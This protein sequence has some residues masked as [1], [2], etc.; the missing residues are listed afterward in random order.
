MNAGVL[1][2]GAL[3][4]L[5]A[6]SWGAFKD[7]PFEGFRAGKFARSVALGLA[8]AFLVGRLT[9][10]G[11]VLLLVGLAYCTERLAT[12]WWKAIL[13]EES[14]DAYTIP[15][16]LAFRG[17]TVERRLIRY[18]VG[19][20]VIG[21]LVLTVTGAVALQA[22]GPVPS[23]WTL[24]MLGGL[25]GWLTAVGGAWKD[26]P[27]E[28]FETLKFFRSPVVATLWAWVLLPFTS[29]LP[30]LAIAAAGW[31]VITIETYKTFLAG[32]PPGKFGDKPVRF[33][34]G[35]VR[36]ACRAVHSGLY[37][38]LTGVLAF[39]VFSASLPG[40][41]P[42]PDQVRAELQALVL[43]CGY[44]FVVLIGRAPLPSVPG[45]VVS[46]AVSPARSGESR[47]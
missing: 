2:I 18:T 21:G 22:R 7:S 32:G 45:P 38:A 12:E 20:L 23:S 16:R 37:A 34:S 24:V 35:G 8:A 4:G 40:A 41:E 42:H 26:A 28:G 47:V 15:M 11:D 13:R 3:T 30:V 44:A 9:G 5:H 1:L 27:I 43:C 25:G 19:V 29:S 31:S 39:L 6:A 46:P 10:S 36:R 14:Q 17:R 33:P